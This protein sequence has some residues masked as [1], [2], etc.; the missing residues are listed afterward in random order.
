MADASNDFVQRLVSIAGKWTSYAGFGT[1]LLYLFG[2]L[3]LRFQL[4]TYGV[5]T[6]LDL[7]DEKYLFA[8]CRFLV[9]I[10]MVLPNLL[11]L[12]AIVAL[13]LAILFRLMPSQTRQR[14]WAAVQNWLGRPYRPQLVGCV[15]ALIMIQFLL[16]QCLYL[17][18]LLLAPCLPPDWISSV[19][20]A[21]DTAQAVY[22][23]GLVAGIAVTAA[24]LAYALRNSDNTAGTRALTT[25]F[26]V[27][28]A[29]ECL[30]LPINYGMLVGSRSLP[31]VAQANTAYKLS[32][33]DTAWLVWEN[34]DVLTYF[35]RGSNDA[36]R[37]ITVPRKDNEITIV[38]NDPVFQTIFAGKP[39]CP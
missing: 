37:I 9:Y 3:T 24:L 31:R 28:F 21:S 14:A 25:V 23:A 8:G 26:V 32:D 6:N 4:N 34:K 38:G 11:F 30:L 17:S 10:G 13:L 18:N 2:Y 29:I 33:G 16:R 35:V 5:A 12:A 39:P 19:F 7:F 20:L 36:R 27:L 22:F 15:V 1:F